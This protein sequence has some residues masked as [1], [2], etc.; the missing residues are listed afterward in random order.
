MRTE[1]FDKT[2]KDPFKQI[3]KNNEYMSRVFLVMA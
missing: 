1:W 3:N 2:H